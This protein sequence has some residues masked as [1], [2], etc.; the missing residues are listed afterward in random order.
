MGGKRCRFLAKFGKAKHGSVSQYRQ[1]MVTFGVD[2]KGWGETMSIEEALWER[3][4]LR[5]GELVGKGLEVG[6]THKLTRA[7]GTVARRAP[8][9]SLSGPKGFPG[10]DR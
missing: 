3:A 7:D 1:G 2:Q 6:I 8:V 5:V 9:F 4:K 10:V